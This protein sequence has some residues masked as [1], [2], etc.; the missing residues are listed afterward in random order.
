HPGERH[1]TRK[2]NA[3]ETRQLAMTNNNGEEFLQTR[4]V[5]LGSN[6]PDNKPNEPPKPAVVAIRRQDG[7]RI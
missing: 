3:M 6:W 1:G 5:P 4:T 2:G 7:Q